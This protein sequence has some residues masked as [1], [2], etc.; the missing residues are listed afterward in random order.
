[1]QK[2][3]NYLKAFFAFCKTK[4]EQIE[5]LP[6]SSLYY[7]GFFIFIILLRSLLED[8]SANT[9]ISL[10]MHLHFVFYYHAVFLAIVCVLKVF[11]DEAINKIFQISSICFSFVLI[12]PVIDILVFG[13]RVSRITYYQKAQMGELAARY[14]TFFGSYSG[15]GATPGIRIHLLL[16]ILSV[17]CYIFIKKGRKFAPAAFATIISYTILFVS[18]I[19]PLISEKYVNWPYSDKLM[20]ILF[21]QISLFFA[22]I[23]LL[24]SNRKLAVSVFKDGRYLRVFYYFS[25]IGMGLAI[26][27]RHNQNILFA[28]FLPVVFQLFLCLLLAIFF[29]IVSN[30]RADLNIDKVCNKDRPLIDNKISV[31]DYQ[32]FGYVCLALSLAG[33]AIISYRALFFIF[34]FI[35]VYYFYSMPPLRLKRVTFFS[36]LAISLNSLFMV[37]LGYS[38]YLSPDNNGYFSFKSFPVE[39]IWF[40]LVFTFAANFIDIKDYEGDKRE[41]IKTLPVVLGL[42]KAKKLIGVFFAFPFLFIA[43]YEPDFTLYCILFSLINYRIINAGDYNENK[44]FYSFLTGIVLLIYSIV[45]SE[46]GKGFLFMVS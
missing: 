2:T 17:G 26:G 33:A 22:T 18:S 40:F 31:D 15:T 24:I 7:Y 9:G 28:Y 30:N 36:K 41:N 20:S 25:L 8:F 12:G 5:N 14:L 19:F 27:F 44:L 45:T 43:F 6:G 10:I 34:L 21:F 46:P 4:I 35:A 32:I 23:L 39:Y 16:I 3:K 38:M 1:M 42:E 11:S 13:L 29:S 37:L